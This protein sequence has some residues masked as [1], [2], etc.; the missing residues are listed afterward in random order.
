MTAINEFGRREIVTSALGA[1]RGHF[2]HAVVA[3][4]TVY[5]CG[6]MAV[7]DNAVIAPGDIERQSEHIFEAMQLILV[8][9]GSSLAGIVALTNYVTD[10]SLRGSANAARARILGSIKPVSTLVEVSALAAPG[11]VI[12]IDAIAVVSE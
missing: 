5:V 8:D 1:P 4:G 12:E 10:I 11:A 3:R 7:A 2:S 6:L 9:A